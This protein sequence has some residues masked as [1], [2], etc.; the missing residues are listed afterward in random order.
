MKLPLDFRE[1]LELFN[2]KGIEHMI[3]GSYALASSVSSTSD[4]RL[5]TSVRPVG[6][7][8]VSAADG[9]ASRPCHRGCR[10]PSRS[11][12]LSIHSIISIPSTTSIALPATYLHVFSRQRRAVRLLISC[13]SSNFRFR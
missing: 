10:A 1:F 12:I 7:I 5:T 6:R 2:A 13:R 3:V 9:S 11:S 8:F 4:Q